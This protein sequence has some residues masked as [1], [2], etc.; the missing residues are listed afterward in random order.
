M[1]VGLRISALMLALSVISIGTVSFVLIRLG[2]GE[3]Q[4]LSEGVAVLRA[5]AVAGELAQF[6]NFH[7]AAVGVTAAVMERYDAVPLESRRSYI[8]A[9]VRDVMDND[10]TVLTS[11]TIWMPNAVDGNDRAAIGTPG[12]TSTGQLLAAYVRT[13][14]GIVPE[15]VEAY[16]N[17]DFWT[18]PTRQNRQ[19]VLNPYRQNLGGRDHIMTSIVAP[20]RNRQGAVIAVFGVDISLDSLERMGQEIQTTY[21]NTVTA[22]FS[23]NGSIISHRDPSRLG[24]NMVDV[25]LELGQNRFTLASDIRQGNPSRFDVMDGGTH[26]RVFS[27]PF[28]VGNFPDPWG[29][30]LAVD[31]DEVFAGVRKMI[32]FG[33]ITLL[34]TVAVAGAA[35]ILMSRNVSKPIARMA[36]V[37]KDIATGD[38]DLTVRLPDSG[39]DEIGEASQYFNKTIEKI[40]S[41]VLVIKGQAAELSDIG[42]TLAGKMTQ[43]AS[44]TNEIAAN[45]QSI[46]NRVVNQS[47]S[48]TETHATMEQVTLNIDKLNGHVERQANAVMQASSAIEEMFANIQSVTSILVN[49]ADNV[50]ELKESS[51]SGRSSLQEVA[52]NIQE[53][54]RESAGL[55]EI[56]AMMEN[57]ASQTNLLSMNAAI[58]AAHAGESGKGFAV[59]AD[60]IRK[61]AESSSEQSKTIGTVLKKIKESIDKITHSTNSALTKFD[62]I[63]HGVKT[64]AGQEEIIRGAMEE[65]TEGSRQ[66][67]AASGQVSDI[68]QQVKGGSIEMLA[69]SK[70]VILE[71]KNLESTTQEITLGINE[72]AVGA[73]E[74]NRVVNSV[75]DLSSKNRENISELVKAVSQFKV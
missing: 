62:S 6:L 73:E 63:E 66:V 12:A 69:G 55:L 39:R 51:E 40:R 9:L 28:Y 10:Q 27:A 2:S 43:S 22:A 15:M 32:L 24:R 68:T 67:L 29:F 17:E 19:V 11:W 53:I 52:A 31:V 47:A 38:G 41:L 74:V 5:Q 3:V 16:E 34:I 21:K 13:P 46:K 75:N 44:A 48:V 49:N 72:M 8:S 56:N 23:N 25:E 64:V 42:N 61:L 35:A 1:K 45:I 50:N 71:S 33:I 54:E 36:S 14:A 26:L 57:I 37:L 59:V 20:I 4:K 58:E 65:Q 7:W 70:E 18:L 30:A 60:E